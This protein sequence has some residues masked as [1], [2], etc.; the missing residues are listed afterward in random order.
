[1]AQTNVIIDLT[2]EKGQKLHATSEQAVYS[3]TA[4]PTQTNEII[5]LTGNPKLDNPQGTLVGDTITYDL[6]SGK[7]RA[8]NQRMF[9]RQDDPS[10]TNAPPDTPLTNAVPVSTNVPAE[11]KPQ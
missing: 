7:V 5:E 8:T 6:R 2:D 1:V 10:P 9:V 11:A 3:Y 4:T